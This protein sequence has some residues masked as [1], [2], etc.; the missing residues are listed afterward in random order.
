MCTIIEI[1]RHITTPECGHVCTLANQPEH[2]QRT[3][4][5]CYFIGKILA[6]KGRI[7]SWRITCKV[8]CQCCLDWAVKI[9][10]PSLKS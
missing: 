10:S 7:M 8:D 1:D 9:A 2:Q 5:D 3:C 6:D 4:L